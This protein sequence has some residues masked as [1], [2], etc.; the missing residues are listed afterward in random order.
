MATVCVKVLKNKILSI[1]THILLIT[2]MIDYFPLMPVE[3]L[4]AH[5]FHN[6]NRTKLLVKLKC[7]IKLLFIEKRKKIKRIK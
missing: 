4:P 3:Q 2:R 1:S 5:V 7:F 6:I